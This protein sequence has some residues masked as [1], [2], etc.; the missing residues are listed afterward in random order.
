MALS[1]MEL[2]E[3]R[4]LAKHQ[5][6]WGAHLQRGEPLTDPQMRRWIESGL[7]EAQGTDGYRLTAIGHI[8]INA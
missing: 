2:L 6:L 5:P 7:I 1:K 8:E 3:L 4:Y